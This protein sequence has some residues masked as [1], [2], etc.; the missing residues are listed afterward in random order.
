MAPRPFWKGHLKLS[1][2]S[3]PVTMSPATS[4]AEKVKFHTLNRR[5]GNRI[6]AQYIDAITE[7]PLEDADAVRGF[8]RGENDYLILEDTELEAV[9]L[10]TTK[11]IDIDVFVPTD[12]VGW[13]WYDKPHY[14]VPDGKVSEE[15]FG[16]IRDA[17]VSTSTVGIARLVLYNRERAVLLKPRETGM[18]VWTLHYGN[19][20]RD[21][22]LYF[23]HSDTDSPPDVKKLVQQLITQ[24]TKNWDPA[25]VCD[26]VQERLLD[27]IASKKKGRAKRPARRAEEAVPGNVVNIMDALRRSLGTSRS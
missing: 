11:T 15:A 3:C 22:G 5:T 17:M 24:R 21:R 7:A 20:V 25:M 4:E 19:E 1:L 10:E 6:R 18:V 9:Q 16:V 23:P 2:V 12:H 27:I 14:L 13:I 26:P 8:A